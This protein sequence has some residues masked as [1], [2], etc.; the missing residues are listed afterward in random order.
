MRF[1]RLSPPSICIAMW[2]MR[3]GAG[4]M[5]K[6]P[7]VITTRCRAES[8]CTPRCA[9]G[10]GAECDRLEVYSDTPNAA[11]K[12]RRGTALK[13]SIIGAGARI[14]GDDRNRQDTVRAGAPRGRQAGAPRVRPVIF[15]N[16]SP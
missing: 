1:T 14:E 12:G 9:S 15:R 4:G 8:T 3:G 5:T 10:G 7:I 11:A 16:H 2:L 13:I 6:G